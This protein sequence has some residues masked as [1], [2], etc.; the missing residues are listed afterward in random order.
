MIWPILAV[1]LPVAFLLSG[2]GSALLNVSRV[3]AR[4]SAEE[5]DRSA[6]RLARLLD[7][8]NEL[9]HAVTVLQ[10]LFALAAF[11]CCVTLLVNWFGHWG[12]LVAIVVV[13]PVFLV[14]L[15]FVPKLLFRRYPFRLLR[16]LSTPLA[17]VHLLAR[18]WIWFAQMI[19]RRANLTSPAADH[20][21]G[22]QTLAE[23]VTTFGVLPTSL[24]S[25]VQKTADFKKLH[26]AD[27]LMQL[28]E[29]IALPAD[30]PL[31][32]AVALNAQPRHPWRA[33]LGTDGRLLGWLDMTALPPKP[34][35]DKLVRQ[36][37][38]PVL[39]LRK[40]DDAFRCLQALRKRGEPV[41]AV[42]NVDGTA[43]GVLTQQDL[44]K[45]LFGEVK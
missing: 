28:V 1:S 24:C 41:A 26:A 37:M 45:A 27:L 9:H 30:M 40:D 8:R 29:L 3:R 13:L 31:A 19:K 44:I 34:S 32:S 20:S 7:H 6:A 33:V 38:R 17:W 23:T 10:H 39:Q 11:A 43:I 21:H 18:P 15:E 16:R 12:W 36:F 22:L 2:I 35:T 25:L 14:G 42:L 5:G 4:H